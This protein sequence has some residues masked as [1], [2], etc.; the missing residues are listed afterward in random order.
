MLIVIC[1]LQKNEGPMHFTTKETV[2][3]DKEGRV[4]LPEHIFNE[5]Q[6]AAPLS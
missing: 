5:V 1:T 6:L 3:I 4:T 2:S